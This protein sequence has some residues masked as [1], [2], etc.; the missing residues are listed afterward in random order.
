MSSESISLTLQAREILGKKVKA[1]R[2]EGLVPAVIHNHGKPSIPVLAKYQEMEKVY[3]A[4]GGHHPVDLTIG[5]EKFLALI[6]DVDVHPTKRTLRHLVFQALNVNETTEAEIPIHLEGE[7]PAERM[8]LLVIKILEH[9]NVE[10]LPRNLPDA[11]TVDA[12]KLVE[13]GDKLTVAD[14]KVP[15]GVTILN[16]P[17][18]TIAAV[19]EP[20]VHEVEAPEAEVAEGEESAD[21]AVAAEPSESKEE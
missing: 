12:T 9:V 8:S 17:E 1:L 14:I 5:K 6:K 15:E 13:I 10:A 16:D 18:Q 21:G 20:K 2:R 7:I 3:H 11:L 4:A 19:E